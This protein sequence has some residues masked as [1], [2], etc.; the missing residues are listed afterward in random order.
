MKILIG[1]AFL[2]FWMICES[3][4]STFQRG[5]E[6]LPDDFKQIRQ[7]VQ[8]GP[9]S[10]SISRRIEVEGTVYGYVTLSPKDSRLF[11]SFNDFSPF[12]DLSQLFFGCQK[13]ALEYEFNGNIDSRIGLV[14]KKVRP[15][16]RSLPLEILYSQIGESAHKRLGEY[17]YIFCG[18]GSGGALASL[19]AAYFS[20]KNSTR[21]NQVKVITFSSAGL[22]D[23][24]FLRSYNDQIQI[25]NSLNFK[26]HLDLSISRL[27][28]AG[29]PVE[30][31]AVEGI[32][33][34]IF[35]PRR[36]FQ[37]L[38]WGSIIATGTYGVVSYFEL[39]QFFTSTVAFV[40]NMTETMVTAKQSF[41]EVK[42]LAKNVTVGSME[43][44]E[45]SLEKASG[46][47]QSFA[48]NI[49]AQQSINALRFG[50]VVSALPS[51][52][53]FY[54][55]LRMVDLPSD[56][57]IAS[58]YG[59]ARSRYRRLSDADYEAHLQNIGKIS[60]FGGR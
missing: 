57:L 38:L 31:T 52:Y 17:D 21:E 48:G 15:M 42:S 44:L 13:Q 7:L 36:A 30:I 53:G 51:V 9:S 45:Q 22:G 19:V 10:D 18:Y 8:I 40:Q 56:D 37:K 59:Y 28:A 29:M 16:V 11:V 20:K 55:L 23:Q 54:R 24:E 14:E 27:Y 49:K 47:P 2:I 4:A 50:M 58:A 35:S 12:S 1:C 5:L 32:F 33:D 43:V 46:L 26:R 39:A 6:L 25:Y 34:H 3:D 41:E 60:W